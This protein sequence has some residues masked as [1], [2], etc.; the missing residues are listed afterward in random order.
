MVFPDNAVTISPGRWRATTDHVFDRRNKRRHRNRGLQLR[1]RANRAE[2]GRAAR[3]V[4]LH[5]FHA[6]GRLDRNT[7]RVER[8]T[9]ADQREMIG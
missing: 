4:V 6:V 5:F 7:A 1:D 3:H 8:D 2:H 9:F